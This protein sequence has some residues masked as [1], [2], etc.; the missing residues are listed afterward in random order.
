MLY[1]AFLAG[2]TALAAAVGW[3]TQELLVTCALLVFRRTVFVVVDPAKIESVC[4]SLGAARYASASMQFRHG[5]CVPTGLVYGAGVLAYISHP[6]GEAGGRVF[7]VATRERFDAL[8]AG[9][10]SP[11]A[12]E[13]DGCAESAAI[14]KKGRTLVVVYERGGCYQWLYYEPRDLDISLLDPSAAQAQ[15]VDEI[16]AAYLA[17]RRRL[18]VFLYGPPGTGKTS[19]AML[20][21]AR[22]GATF[23]KTCNPCEPGDSLTTVLRNVLPTAERPHVQ[24]FDE[25]D[26]MIRKAHAREVVQHKNVPVSVYDKSSLNRF[27]D[28]LAYTADMLVLCTS[29]TPKAWIDENLD[30]CYLRKGR[31][32]MVLTLAR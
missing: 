24:L 2:A 21:A 10:D 13:P 14:D 9:D 5:K 31:V 22:L 8:T 20:L 17:H 18:T 19:L 23:C 28:D 11:P 32:D 25:F 1:Y 29:N 6:S 16:V 3:L 27:M 15:L 30:A 7:V 4:R 26:V 12:Y